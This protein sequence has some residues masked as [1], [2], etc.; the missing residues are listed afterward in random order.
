M[1]GH[2][3]IGT[4]TMAIENGLVRAARRRACC[5][6]TRRPAVVV[7]Q[8][9]AG[10][11]SFVEQR[12]HP[13]RR[14]PTSPRRTWRSTCPGSASSAST[15]PMA[16]TSTPSSSRSRISR[17]LDAMRRGGRAAPQPGAAPEASTRRSRSVHPEDATIRGVSHVMWTG[18]PRDRGAPMPAT[19][20]STATRR[21]TARPAAPAPRRAWRSSRREGEL[22][23]GDEFVHESIIGT[24]FDGRV[25][26]AAHGRQPRRDHPLAS[27][28]GRAMTGLNTIFVDDRDPLR[29]GFMV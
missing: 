6:S 28:A 17:G 27:P 29:A 21:S 3:T 25:E 22:A 15:S 5:G 11:A 16:A 14:R 7:A 10:T 2:G 8:L 23:V 26:A 19:P 13:Q 20:C 12:A 4:V 24:L 18:K 1:C 9:R